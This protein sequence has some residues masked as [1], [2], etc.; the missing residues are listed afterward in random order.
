VPDP[1]GGTALRL[2]TLHF[3]AAH[4]EAEV[5]RAAADRSW[6]T[7]RRATARLLLQYLAQ[8]KTRLNAAGYVLQWASPS[9]RGHE[10]FEVSLLG[11]DRHQLVVQRVPPSNRP[12]SGQAALPSSCCE[13]HHHR[14]Q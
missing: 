3:N 6:E 12:R 13:Q 1:E 5:R 4:Y 11:P 2:P 14:G 10:L 7:A 8:E 9:P